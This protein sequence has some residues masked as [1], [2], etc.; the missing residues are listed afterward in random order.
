MKI[1]KNTKLGEILENY[2]NAEQVL[3]GFGMHCFSCPISQMESVEEAS[4]VHDLDLD[5]V[6]NKMNEKLEPKKAKWIFNLLFFQN[7]NRRFLWI[8]AK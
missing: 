3:M 8:K 1:T 4:A 6:L 2:E 7:K 5:F